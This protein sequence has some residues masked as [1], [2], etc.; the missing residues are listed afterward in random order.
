MNRAAWVWRGWRERPVEAITAEVQEWLSGAGYPV[1]TPAELGLGEAEV[2]ALTAG[3]SPRAAPVDY[4]HVLEVTLAPVQ[5]G[6]APSGFSMTMGDS[7]P[8]GGARGLHAARCSPRAARSWTAEPARGGDRALGPGGAQGRGGVALEGVRPGPTDRGAGCGDPGDL[9]ALARGAE[10]RSNGGR[11]GR[12]DDVRVG[13]PDRGRPGR[14]D[15]QEKAA[16]S[17]TPAPAPSARP[18]ARVFAGYS[19]PG[20]VSSGGRA[21]SRRRRIQPGHGSEPVA[22][23]PPSVSTKRPRSRQARSRSGYHDSTFTAVMMP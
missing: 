16:V 11:A 12:D 14:G 8:R 23:E 17:T 7:D 22:A 10:S 1:R 13:D 4:S 5:H 3:R 19:G 9:R 2:Q 21:G 20:A 18:P 15:R 6:K